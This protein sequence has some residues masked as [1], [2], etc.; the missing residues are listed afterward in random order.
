MF[1]A[2][3]FIPRPVWKNE[4]VEN[5]TWRTEFILLGLT[6]REELQL[7]LFLIFLL[8]YLMTVLV[9]IGII[10]VISMSPQLHNPMYILLANLSFLDFSYSS[11]ICPR[12]LFD[13]LHEKKVISF[14]G[15]ILQQYFFGALATVEFF[16]LAAMAFDR[17]V[18]VC[19][20]L[21]YITV[22][23]RMVCIQLVVCSYATGFLDS[24]LFTCYTFQLPLCSNKLNHFFCDAPLLLRLSC[25][26]T[27]PQEALLFV[28]S[29]LNLIGTFLAILISYAKI[30]AAILRIRSAEGKQRAFSTCSSHL[31]CVIIL[32][33]TLL[34]MY[35][36]PSSRY[37][38]EHEKV[39]SVFYTIVIP[40]VN[41]LIYCLRNKEVKGALNTLRKRC[42]IGG[43]VVHPSAMA[44]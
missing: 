44:A 3:Y 20:P 5:E 17:Y 9:N 24:T 39:V 18:A 4:S 29:C 26:D 40:L 16:L 7:P 31:S 41:P 32:Y 42:F 34:F 23:N 37:S 6:D 27:Y 25:V 10:A 2:I 22:M 15:C 19:N 11:S 38:L 8:I 12:T 43:A 30:V 1:L 13:L 33:G 36:R 28:F 14:H 21:H 35:F